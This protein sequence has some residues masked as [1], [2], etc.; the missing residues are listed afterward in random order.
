M[1]KALVAIVKKKIQ[2]IPPRILFIPSTEFY[3]NTTLNDAFVFQ[4]C[5]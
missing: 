4:N 3:K 2:K 5:N 1:V